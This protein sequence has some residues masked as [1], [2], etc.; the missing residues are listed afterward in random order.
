MW[1]RF[2]PRQCRP[3]DGSTRVPK[4]ATAMVTALLA[5]VLVAAVPAAAGQTTAAP[6]TV[7][8]IRQ[9][10][11]SADSYTSGPSTRVIVDDP[12][13]AATGSVFAADL[14]AQSGM[15]VPVVVNS[16]ARAG[17][18]ELRIA[19]V[20]G[21][22]SSEAYQVMVGSSI[23]IQAAT[24]TG[25]F[26]GT[27]SVSQWLHQGQS[28]AGGVATDW[29]TYAERGLLLDVGREYV[30]IPVLRQE[31]RQLAY[32]K[33]NYL[34]LH[35]SDDSGFRLASDTHP[36]IVSALHYTKQEIRDL[37][38]YATA[39]HVQIV[40]EIDFP[41]HAGAIL[42]AHPELR[43]SLHNGL[44]DLANPAAYRLIG[45]LITEFLPLFPGRYWHIGGDEYLSATGQNATA[46]DALYGYLDWAD[47]IVRAAGKTARAWND[48]LAPGNVTITVNPDIV[49]DHWSQS[50]FGA[51]P[52]F[53]P[54]YTAPQLVA[55]G[56]LVANDAFTPTY[57]TAGL[58]GQLL[59]APTAMLY[60]AWN[61]SVF[62]DGST[63]TDP[64][65]DLGSMLSVWFD[66]PNALPE[67]RLADTIADRLAVLSQQTWGSPKPVPIYLLFAPLIT[68]VGHAP[69]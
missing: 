28:V 44:I 67:N 53:G 66:D 30:S 33:L 55:A 4:I 14:T 10:S 32:L 20:P 12:A 19:P 6:V 26:D 35:F 63:V 5:V 8:A 36:E 46:Q 9:W 25:V 62:V 47:A 7:P 68:A 39:Y 49:I 16:G 23:T 38:G 50:G 34:Q 2:V 56:H 1:N 40:P 48:G 18:I 27:R 17:D 45:D 31:I 29:P 22:T 58:L 64:T 43:D 15:T 24:D 37:V 41:A 54:A 57:Y 42:A 51:V 11:P 61:P 69:G 21:S 52:W 65:R 3:A 60:D 13:L 59:T